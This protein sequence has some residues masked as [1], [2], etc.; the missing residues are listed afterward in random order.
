[1]RYYGWYSNKARGQRLK[2]KQASAVPVDAGEGAADTAEVIDVSDYKAKRRPSKKWRELIKKVWEVDPMI[3]PKCGKPMKVIAL[4]DEPG[5]IFD[6]LS[7]LGLWEP[8]NEQTRPRAPPR[9]D[10]VAYSSPG[11]PDQYAIL[12][13][14]ASFDGIDEL[15]QDEVP[16]ILYD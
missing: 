6:I 3:C 14:D 11:E 5:A 9:Q 12:Y 2:Q 13:E 15:P 1:M 7:Y 16:T 4:I 8:V 10:S